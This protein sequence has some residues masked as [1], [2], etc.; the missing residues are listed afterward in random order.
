MVGDDGRLS[1]LDGSG[2]GSSGAVAGNLEDVVVHAPTGDLLVLSELTAELILYAPGQSDE[3]PVQARHAALLGQPAAEA[4]Q[5]FEGLAFRPDTAEAGGGVFYLTN[6]RG[7][8]M[9]VAI[10]FDPAR[11]A[12]ASLGA[13]VVKARWP[14][15]DYEDLT[16]ITYVAA[17]DRLLIIADKADELLVMHM[18]GHVERRVELPGEQQEGLA[19]DAQGTLWVA[20]DKDKSVLKI[21]GALSALQKA[22]ADGRGTGLRIPG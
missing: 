1:E 3:A 11:A 18:D 15:A 21:E 14:L 4:N 12:P 2:A 5:G 17:L 13:E 9:V 16:A 22:P 19:M 7:P 10:A 20:D 8:A 6:Q